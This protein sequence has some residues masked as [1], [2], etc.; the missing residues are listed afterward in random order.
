[1]QEFLHCVNSQYTPST[2]YEDDLSC[3]PLQFSLEGD[4]LYLYIDPSRLEYKSSLRY[5]DLHAELG[6]LQALK[7]YKIC[8]ISSC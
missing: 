1:M 6:Q 3:T 7:R 4:Y 8:D 5:L 2:L